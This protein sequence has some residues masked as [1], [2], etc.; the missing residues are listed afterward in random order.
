[1]LEIIQNESASLTVYLQDGA[2]DPATGLTPSD[3]TFVF[4]KPGATSVTNKALD[5][6]NFSEVDVTEMP[7]LYEIALTS[8]EMDTVG[9]F[10]AVIQADGGADV[11]RANV[12]LQVK[13]TNPDVNLTPV[14]T[15][16][17]DMK[18]TG[19]DTNTD[20][21]EQIR[22]NASTDLGPVTTSLDEIK[23]TGF[24]TGTDSL[25]QTRGVLDTHT[26][27]LAT[28]DSDVKEVKASA[29]RILGLSQENIRI[30]GQTYDANNNLTNSTISLYGS[31]AD[32]GTETNPIAVYQLVASY[33][34]NNRL[35]DYRIVKT[36]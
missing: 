22:D 4:R 21:L 26:S 10:V 20:S 30:T 1:M 5:N 13:P 12:R 6:S 16:L 36:A 28:I 34:T 31:A 25:A 23:G 14:T 32:V 35:T 2:G 18:G 9:E 29:A 27:T 33:D 17:D 19:F 24:A 15:V 3:V 8:G 11:A 7:G